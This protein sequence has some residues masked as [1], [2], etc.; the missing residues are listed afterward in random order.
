M[1]IENFT[2][3]ILKNMKQ[4]FKDC[5]VI[6]TT[7]LK[8]N[9]IELNG[10]VFNREGVSISPCI[11]I[12]DLYEKYDKGEVS[13]QQV[14]EEVSQRYDSSLDFDKE[15]TNLDVRL[16]NCRD[17]IIYK[18]IS[19]D[20]NEEML[21]DIPYIPFL[22]FAII[23]LVVVKIDKRG[24]HSIKVDN[25]LLEKWKVTIGEL[26]SIAKD[27]T[28][29]ILPPKVKKLGSIMS[30]IL[31]EDYELVERAKEDSLNMYVVTNEFGI[32]GAS[33][34]IYDHLIEELAERLGD[35]L[36]ILP[37]SIHEMLV[38]V[39]NN[40]G[41]YEVVSDMIRDINDEFVDKE[42]ILSDHPYIYSRSKRKFLSV[43]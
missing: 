6:D 7:T 3:C 33:A 24:M 14:C 29:K 41:S 17:R 40:R 21:K 13:L 9:G 38:M 35:D 27:N 1:T 2:N 18:L 26:Y 4:R 19:Y 34:I 22:D 36:L 10:I 31:G 20:D 16:E 30:E 37:S 43:G 15:Y 42:E 5:D 23:M 8:N 11:Y 25:K 39:D 32:Y 28:M 12:D